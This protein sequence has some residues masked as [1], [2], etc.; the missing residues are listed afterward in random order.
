MQITKQT[1]K[2]RS[3]IVTKSKITPT[4]I[5][6]FILLFTFGWIVADYQIKGDSMETTIIA[7]V[8]LAIPLL[9]AL[10][11]IMIFKA[12]KSTPKN[13]EDKV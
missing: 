11:G 7:S 8:V 10:I 3:D 1:S 9:I 4:L 13:C 5:G 12:K 6:Q 2:K